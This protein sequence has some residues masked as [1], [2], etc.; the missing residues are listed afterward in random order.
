MPAMFQENG[1][2]ATRSA[3]H[4][5]H[6]LWI[7]LLSTEQFHT[8]WGPFCT[9]YVQQHWKDALEPLAAVGIWTALQRCVRGGGKE[10]AVVAH[11]RSQ[12]SVEI[13]RGPLESPM[14]STGR[15]TEYG[16]WWAAW[17]VEKT[18]SCLRYLAVVRILCIVCTKSHI[19]RWKLS[20]LHSPSHSEGGDF[21]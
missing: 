11:I 15:F 8:I 4:T 12:E 21:S 3:L 14:S 10:E 17:S 9:F 13:L 5:F 6:L 7:W 16:S 20:K 18:T 1:P 19:K 2:N